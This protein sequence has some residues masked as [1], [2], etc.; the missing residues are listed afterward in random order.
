MER[1]S[2]T[3]PL[4][5]SSCNPIAERARKFKAQA[6]RAL[7]VSTDENTMP[8]IQVISPDKEFDRKFEEKQ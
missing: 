6:Q 4:R 1:A 8:L 3:S 5:I 2:S 7:K